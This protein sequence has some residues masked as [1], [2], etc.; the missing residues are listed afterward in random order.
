[1]PGEYR[2]LIVNGAKMPLTDDTAPLKEDEPVRIYLDGSF[3]GIAARR[4]EE[5]AWKVQ[6]APEDEPEEMN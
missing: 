6:I 4:E 2:K 1:M 3:W 5:L